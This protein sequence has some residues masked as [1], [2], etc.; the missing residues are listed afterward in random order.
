MDTSSLAR[1]ALATLAVPSQHARLIRLRAPIPGL[2]VERF[3]G[4]E[5]VCGGFR[6]QVDVIATSTFLPTEDLLGQVLSLH[7]AQPDGTPRTWHALCTAVAP[8]G[9][10]GGLARYR[11][12]LEPWTALLEHRR[13][14]LIFQ[15]LDVPGVLERIFADYPLARWRFE[16]TRKLP[17]RPISTQYR[18]SD[19]EFTTR[20]LAGAGLAWRFEHDQDGHAAENGP[21]HVLVVFD[22][23]A[24][25]PEGRA[26]RFH[27]INAT[28]RDDAISDFAQRLQVT[29]DGAQMA[30][31]HARHLA[32]IAGSAGADARAT[33]PHL[34]VYATDGE[35]AYENVDEAAGA[36][37][38]LLDALRLPGRQYRGGGSVRGMSPGTVYSIRQHSVHEGQRFVP[39]AVSH[40]A[41]NNL[42]AGISAL[43]G[44]SVLERGSYRNRFTAVPAG[45]PIVPARQ[46]KPTAPGPQTALVVGTPGASVSS[47]RDHQVRIQFAWQRGHSPNPGGL[48]DAASRHPGHAPGDHTSGTWVP[49]A[50]SMAGPDWGSHFLP[51]IGT[52]VLVE[53][54]HGDIDQPRITGQLYNGEALPPFGGD[55]DPSSGHA[56][57]VSGLHTRCEPDADEGQQW[58]IDDAPGQLRTRLHTS[59]GDSRLELGYLVSHENAQRG[60]LRGEGFELA[61]E[62]WGSVRAGEGLLLSSTARTGAASSQLDAAD[63]V[64][65]LR[66]AERTAGTLDET[67]RQQK[68]P[69][70]NANGRLSSL[71]KAADPGADAR[72]PPTVAGQPALKPGSG[73]EPGDEPVERFAT[74]LL[75]VES[76]DS[77][78]ITTGKSAA[79]CAGGALHVTV[80]QDA[81]LSAGNSISTVS[82]SHAA[83]YSHGGPLRA[84]AANG[85][86]SL[87]AH[88]GDL[89]L[90][91]DQGASIQSTDDRVEVLAET[92]VLRAGRA[93]VRLEGEDIAFECPGDFIVKGAQQPF[94]SGARDSA[95]IAP[96]PDSRIPRFDE[97]FILKDEETG[98]PL[99]NVRYRIVRADGS[100]EQG[101]TDGEGRTHVVAA[102]E[103]EPLVLEVADD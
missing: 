69:A 36:A 100:V 13:N 9:G 32:T 89:E 4:T 54:A 1:Q 25:L 42:G 10:D 6:F 78:A 67:L 24:E 11:L 14:A 29:P 64:A 43:L 99:P 94:S 61:T 46:P 26:L 45:T 56:G 60:S 65:Q 21:G 33:A 5:A 44:S 80:Q 98:E 75:F 96:L 91:A 52:E 63:A 41:A 79:A 70:F 73:R 20:L 62:G 18:E 71:R 95:E 66:G 82:G 76:P 34:Q 77:I 50:E 103:A 84:I 35:R 40:V 27:R 3:E 30:S 83:L 68:V 15:D 12:R 28:E 53:F 49:V 16:I 39:L 74:P 58:I 57:T 88:T 8:L 59:L 7:L 48:E 23:Q 101:V 93:Q 102:T 2:A 85:P 17:V 47:N 31:W 37:G 55:A 38:Q 19:W 92:I 90:L 81:Q 22:Q 87:Q 51:R 72:H 97:G 86:L